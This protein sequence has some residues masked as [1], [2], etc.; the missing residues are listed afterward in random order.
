MTWPSSS[1][2]PRPFLSLTPTCQ[3][4]VVTVKWV[5]MRP[6]Y[7]LLDFGGWFS[8]IWVLLAYFTFN[9]RII[10]IRNLFCIKTEISENWSSIFGLSRSLVTISVAMIRSKCNSQGPSASAFSLLQNV[11]S[12][13]EG[14]FCRCTYVLEVALGSTVEMVLVS[15]G[16]HPF[17][18]HGY[19]FHV[20][21]M[22]VIGVYVSPAFDADS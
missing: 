12:F 7:F 20:V 10:L 17:H 22:G 13:C 14:D 21:A 3:N 19:N 6:C 15:E 5:F 18:L 1:L 8:V 11:S 9:S 16:I 2:R 4:S